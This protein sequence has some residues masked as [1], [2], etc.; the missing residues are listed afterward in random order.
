ALARGTQTLD[1]GRLL[2][3]CDEGLDVIKEGAVESLDRFQGAAAQ[4]VDLVDLLGRGAGWAGIL[5]A[6]ARAFLTPLL[7]GRLRRR[8]GRPQR[9]DVR[10]FELAEGADVLLVKRLQDEPVVFRRLV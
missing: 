9:R 2:R 8:Q 6:A 10:S 5:L 3:C 7:A 4:V 1:Q